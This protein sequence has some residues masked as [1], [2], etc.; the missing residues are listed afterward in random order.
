MS[1]R[2]H[3][4][5][6]RTAAMSLMGENCPSMRD[7]CGWRL[8]LAFHPLSLQCRT[9]LDRFQTMIRKRSISDLSPGSAMPNQADCLLWERR[10]KD[11]DAIRNAIKQPWS[12]GQVEGQINKLKMV[13]RQMYGRAKIRSPSSPP[14]R[15]IMIKRHRKCVWTQFWMLIDRCLRG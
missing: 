14:C 6:L 9:L 12:S 10:S 15:T 4:R 13:K 5:E 8:S 1:P 2:S 11:I 7:I 3:H